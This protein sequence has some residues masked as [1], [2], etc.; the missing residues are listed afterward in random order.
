M[1]THRLLPLG[2]KPSLFAHR[3]LG[4][5]SG[6]CIEVLMM[7]RQ[8]LVGPKQN[9]FSIQNIEARAADVTIRKDAA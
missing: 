5:R 3:T 7:M 8:L 4:C 1:Q 2:W 6:Q 9:R